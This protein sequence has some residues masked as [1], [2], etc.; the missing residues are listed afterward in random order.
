[1]SWWLTFTVGIQ[2]SFLLG[3]DSCYYEELILAENCCY[4]FNIHLFPSAI[5]NLYIKTNIFSFFFKEKID[6]LKTLGAD[7]HPVPAVPFDDPMNYN[8]Q[9]I[10]SPYQTIIPQAHIGHAMID[11]QRSLLKAEVALIIPYP[12]GM[13][14]WINVFSKNAPKYY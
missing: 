1:M 4:Y 3:N 14:E 6:V 5:G 8:H 10:I 13:H 9:V 2:V 11:N 12:T 7:V